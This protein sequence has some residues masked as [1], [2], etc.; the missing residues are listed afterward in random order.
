MSERGGPAA[1]DAGWRR[2]HPITPLLRSWRVIAVFLVVALNWGGDNLA[3]GDLPD[4]NST[5]VAGRWVALGAGAVLLAVLIVVALSYVSWRF[6]RF[7][8]D[9]EAL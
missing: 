9:A 7:R 1:D 6:T 3:H 4:V 2:V 5:D 8:L